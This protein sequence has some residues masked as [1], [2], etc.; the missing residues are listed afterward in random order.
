[1]DDRDVGER[2]RPV[3]VRARDVDVGLGRHAHVADPVAADELVE[4]VLGGDGLRVAEVL[5]DLQRAPDRQHLGAGHVLDAVGERLEVAVVAERDVERVLGALLELGVARADDGE[6][7]LDL[8]PV[9]AQPVVELEVARRVGVGELDAHHP[10]VRRRA[11]E[12]V[13]RRVGAAVL[14]RLEHAGHLRP[15]LPLPVAADDPCDAAHQ[16][17]LP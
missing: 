6:P 5:D 8:G 10:V 14:H 2:I 16:C 9:A 13:A 12:R 4:V 7:P 1:V 11:V 15:D 3:R 17:F